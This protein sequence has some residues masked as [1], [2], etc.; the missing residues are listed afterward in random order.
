[1]FTQTTLAN[2]EVGVLFKNLPLDILLCLLCSKVAFQLPWESKHSA[3]GGVP[4]KKGDALKNL[5]IISWC[6]HMI[7][8]IGKRLK[9]MSA[10]HKRWGGVIYIRDHCL[11]WSSL[12]GNG[13]GRGQEAQWE[14]C[15]IKHNAT[16]E[17]KGDWC[18]TTVTVMRCEL[19]FR[20]YSA[21]L[22]EVLQHQTLTL[23]TC[24]KDWTFKRFSYS[25]FNSWDK[26]SQREVLKASERNNWKLR[27]IR[28]YYQVG[29][30][31][32]RVACRYLQ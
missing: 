20:W 27:V 21:A 3:L 25:S 8:S 18:L 15:G 9:N 14:E 32:W 22:I 29:D 24:Q 26:R 28:I 5:C 2:Q 7:N 23:T 31:I 6:S 4:I 1:M 17:T 30:A 13:R 10:S 11:T 12:L 16:G 19:N